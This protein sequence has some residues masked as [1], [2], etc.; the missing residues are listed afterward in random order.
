M[1]S[2]ERSTVEHMSHSPSQIVSRAPW[3]E[4]PWLDPL[5]DF[6]VIINAPEVEHATTSADRRTD[7][8]T[9]QATA[10]IAFADGTEAIKT[11]GEG[12][13]ENEARRYAA[14]NALI[15]LR[16]RAPYLAQSLDNRQAKNAKKR[17]QRA[18]SRAR[19]AAAAAPTSQVAA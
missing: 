9:V 13:N 11:V 7:S 16:D 6:Q 14:Q 4:R 8:R 18:K 3:L 5:E 10:S 12:P 19:R 17:R 15:I 2:G 1:P